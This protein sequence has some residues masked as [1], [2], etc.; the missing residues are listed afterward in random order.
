MG[1]QI[2]LPFILGGVI[3]YF[4]IRSAARA[5]AEKAARRARRT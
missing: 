4:V 3:S 5:E 2:L 1:L